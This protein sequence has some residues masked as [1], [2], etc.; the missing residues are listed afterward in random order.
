M[1]ILNSFIKFRFFAYLIYLNDPT[2]LLYFDV[3]FR[4]PLVNFEGIQFIINDLYA[5]HSI[6]IN[7]IKLSLNIFFQSLIFILLSYFI[8]FASP[9]NKSFS[10]SIGII[11]LAFALHQFI[12][13][14]SFIFII[15]NLIDSLSAIYTKHVIDYQLHLYQFN[16]V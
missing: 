12:I 14:F 6:S 4:I 5:H 15:T 2:T 1:F 16:L 11:M 8:I 3:A 7:I 10:S 9:I 13:L